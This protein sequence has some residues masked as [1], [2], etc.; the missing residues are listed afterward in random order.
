MCIVVYKPK[1]RL[2]PSEETLRQ[3][4]TRNPDGAGYMFP[5][6][7]KVVIK[8]GYMNFKALYQA[9]MKDY[10]RLGKETPFVLHFR[11]QTQGGVNQECT[12]PFPLSKNMVDLKTLDI[13]SRFGLAHNGIISLTSKSGYTQYYDST[14]RTYRYDYSKPDY[15]DTMKFITD[16][17]AL[18][19]K[20]ENWY[21]DEDTLALIEK[22][23]GYS[24]KF[25]IMD[26]EGHTTLIG[27]FIEDNGIY[28]S[29]STYE[30]YKT[31]S[32]YYNNTT[33][34]TTDEEEDYEK[35]Y[36]EKTCSY[37]FP[38]DNCPVWDYGDDSMCEFCSHWQDCY[39]GLLDALKEEDD[40]VDTTERKCD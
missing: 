14:T 12:H 7:D 16:Y 18:I 24:N 6:D 34:T 15:S 20:T 31:P 2:M 28:Y 5:E 13:E 32:S 22:L 21:K 4:F 10:E 1:D 30:V 39:G 25:A 37:D 19:I 8:K 26:K 40:Y 3:C 23:A 11:I 29:N 9:V 27:N 36:N 17:L 33:T 35:Y 38:I